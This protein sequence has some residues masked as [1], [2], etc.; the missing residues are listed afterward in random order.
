MH[1]SDVP[2]NAQGDGPAERPVFMFMP[3]WLTA[4]RQY[5]GHVMPLNFS[6]AMARYP[7]WRWL[8]Q[9]LQFRHSISEKVPVL[10]PGIEPE[11]YWSIAERF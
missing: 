2:D 7:F 10:P 11:T 8:T 1:Q 9:G 3:I 4:D 5:L 6:L